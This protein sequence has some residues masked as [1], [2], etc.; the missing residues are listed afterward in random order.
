MKKLF[1]LA[2]LV[3]LL[4]SIAWGQGNGTISGT[5]SAEVNGVT[6]PLPYAHVMA[7]T[8]DGNHPIANAM[9]DSSGN[10]TLIVAFG[11]YII[12]AEAMHFVSEWYD[13]V[14]ERSQATAVTVSDGTNPTG[15]SFILAA[16]VPPPPPT[17]GS[18]AG[19]VTDSATTQPVAGA[20]V[21]A[22]G[23][24]PM[25]HFGILTHQDGT[26]LLD[27]I[28]ADTYNIEA[29]GM[30]Y[31]TGHYPNPVVID[32]VAITGIN[33][34]LPPYAP[35]PPPA[36]GSIAGLITD[37]SMGPLFRASVTA[38]G[39]NRM[40]HYTVM[41]EVDGTYLIPNLAADV[42]TVEAH[43]DGFET[44][45]YPNPVTVDSVAITGI[46]IVL[47]PWT[48]PSVGAISGTVTDSVAG[49]P[50]VGASV[51]VY[52]VAHPGMHMAT[53]S[54][55]NGTYSIRVAAGEY[56][57]EAVA[58]G[59][60]HKQYPQH[61]IVADS[62]VVQ[63]ID[64]A[65]AQISYGSIAGVVSDTAG[66]PIGHADVEARMYG[67]RCDAH[68]HTDSTGAY[69]LNHLMPGAYRVSAFHRG[70]TPGVYADTVFV[71]TGGNVS[72]INIVL[73][74]ALPSFNGTISGVVSDDST[75]APISHAMVMGVAQ[76]GDFGYHRWVFRYTFTGDD[77]AYTL[78]NLPQVPFKVFS[79]ARG[80]LGEY[81]DN[82]R[83]YAD[84]TPVTPNATGIN[85]GLT[86]RG[87][88]GPRCLAGNI[89]VPIGY[90]PQGMVV[91]AVQNNEIIDI[92]VTDMLGYYTFSDMVTGTYDLTASSVYGD[93]T[94]D[95]T[96]EASN[97]DI[98]DINIVFSPTS[99]DDNTPALPVASSLN[100]NY[101]N[102]FNAHTMISFVVS[103]PGQVELN[104]FSVTGQKVTTLVSGNYAAGNY[105]VI[106]DGRDAAGN[107]V[108]SGTYYYNL[109]TGN[110]S[111]TMK[112]TLLK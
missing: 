24:N 35:P 31:R 16:V 12:R 93:V 9:V 82:V 46:D 59:Y 14:T 44:G 25:H 11:E 111:Q 90:D 8:H 106:W 30:G 26:Y 76:N 63:G 23:A 32:S 96:I 50:I 33:I 79:N 41:T 110:S 42:Y 83:H 37:P 73:G 60:W 20:L 51:F 112:M 27:N 17:H 7:Y 56:E 38:N 15:I 81:Y 2:V 29:M 105:D 54:G 39:Q 47:T 28:P 66:N 77:G 18:I 34:A 43:R 107:L 57:V 85:F 97:S 89:E 84:A 78:N 74:G 1:C 3:M 92:A 21:F 61:V 95:H 87:E 68:V 22:N 13:N 49:T 62:N 99:V 52:N 40:H 10:Y 65:L 108:S 80:Y 103:N 5:V 64:F 86:A 98:D 75:G 101:P 45:H 71:T 4:G 69:L 53:R 58:E 36:H 70:F 67:G 100:Q 72:D 55:E 6:V 48:P 104:I 19:L 94:L 88:G 109:K 102:P 91:Y